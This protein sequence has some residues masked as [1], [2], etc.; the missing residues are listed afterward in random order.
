MQTPN[1]GMLLSGFPP[2]LAR[3]FPPKNRCAKTQPSLYFY[4]RNVARPPPTFSARTKDLVL[5]CL[6]PPPQKNSVLTLLRKD[7]VCSPFPPSPSEPRPF[8]PKLADLTFPPYSYRRAF[9]ALLEVRNVGPVPPQ[10]QRIELAPL[11]LSPPPL[12]S[13][14]GALKE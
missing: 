10:F 1:L 2:S 6:F 7:V 9:T 3:R 13:P 12:P 4:C 5:H 14:L 8:S 11:C